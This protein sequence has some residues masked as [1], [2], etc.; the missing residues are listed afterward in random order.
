MSV[1]G[2]LDHGPRAAAPRELLLPGCSTFHDSPL[3]PIPR[4]PAAVN[5][6]VTVRAT[7]RLAQNRTLGRGLT[8]YINRFDIDKGEQLSNS[9]IRPPARP[10]P[11]SVSWG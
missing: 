8:Q 2:S 1:T 11:Y 6:H 9:A 10:S 3:A 7:S 4:C 5:V